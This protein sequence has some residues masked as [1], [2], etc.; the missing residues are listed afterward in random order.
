VSPTRTVTRSVRCRSRSLSNTALSKPQ[1]I[2]NGCCA[3]T[4]NIS[5]T[6]RLSPPR[7]HAHLSYQKRLRTLA[8]TRHA[9]ARES[10]GW[11]AGPCMN[12]PSKAN[13]PANF[14]KWSAFLATG[15]GGVDRDA[16]RLR[17]PPISPAAPVG[18]HC[19]AGQLTQDRWR[20]GE[21]WL[22]PGTPLQTQVGVQANTVDSQVRKAH[23]KLCGVPSLL[24]V[25]PLL[26]T[27]GPV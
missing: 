3:S 24:V 11:T 19:C 20:E 13:C 5:L 23:G 7:N 8:R 27:P 2:C 17:L 22:H 15:G 10:M 4:G 25:V 16:F 9:R 6:R 14:S 21:L 1:F 26:S 18:C 12:V